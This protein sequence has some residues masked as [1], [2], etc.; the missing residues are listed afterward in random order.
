[1]QV[2]L[3]HA[4]RE[5][6]PIFQN[7]FQLYI[8]DFSEYWAGTPR[9]DV[10]PDGRFAPYSMDEYW[11]NGSCA[12][13]L[14]YCDAALAGFVLVNNHSH[15]AAAVDHNMAEF[16]VVRKY[17]SC[18]VGR[19]AAEQTF[20]ARPGLWEVAVSRKNVPALSFWRR[21]V[22]SLATIS[23]LHEIDSNNELWNGLVIRFCIRAA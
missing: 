21:V 5:Q 10:Q 19:A 6:E 23:E 22:G 8:H 1:M 17:R 20:A 4:D 11:T 9:G 7:L 14:I 13:S 18:G 15:T 3:K 12:A 2:T 16:F